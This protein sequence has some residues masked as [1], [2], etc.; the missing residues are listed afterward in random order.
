MSQTTVSS[1]MID[2]RLAVIFEEYDSNKD[3]KLS[4]KE[5][6]NFLSDTF[7]EMGKN[8]NVTR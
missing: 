7:K 8:R 1:Q 6:T 2:D 5:L 4:K 3:G